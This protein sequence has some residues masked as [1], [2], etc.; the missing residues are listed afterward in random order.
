[1]KKISETSLDE[2]QWDKIFKLQ[3]EKRSLIQDKDELNIFINTLKEQKQR[4][5]DI[6]AKLESD[7]KELI[8]FIRDLCW[9]VYESETVLISKCECCVFL[10][11][12]K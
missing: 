8:E 2:I 5:F 6:I 7:K 10:E 9:C 3:K 11:G 12:I 1:M 4:A